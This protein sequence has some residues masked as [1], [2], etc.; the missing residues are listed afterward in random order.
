M[1]CSSRIAPC[2]PSPA[3]DSSPRT[4][5]R[6]R[7]LGINA[8][9]LLLLLLS[10]PLSAIVSCRNAD[11]P[12]SG[13]TAKNRSS[14]VDF[15][16]WQPIE[17]EIDRRRSIEG[18]IDLRRLI[19]GEKGKK[20]KKMKRKKREKRR[21][22][23]NTW[24]PRVV[25]ACAPSSP[26]SAFSPMRGDETSPCAGR[27]IEATSPRAFSPTRRRRPRVAGAFS[28]VRRDGTSPSVCTVHIARYWYRYKL[29]T[30]VWTGIEI[31]YRTNIPSIAR[32][33]EA[34]KETAS[35]VALATTSPL[36]AGSGSSREGGAKSGRIEVL[37]ILLLLLSLLLTLSLSFSFFS[38]LL[39]CFSGSS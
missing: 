22:R 19:E 1:R 15:C 39:A 35:S 16:R 36:P 37:P 13:G 30:P 8:P 31:L 7:Q 34:M 33:D 29:G 12:L 6:T 11:L 5:R 28:P 38:T 27:K 17:G 26:A 10:F 9:V 23:N 32:Y 3:G 21:R 14:A 20:K 4:G 25:L 2:Y 18:E 24:R